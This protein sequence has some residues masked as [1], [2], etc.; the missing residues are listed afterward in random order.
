MISVFGTA[1]HVFAAFQSWSRYAFMDC[2]V[3]CLVPVLV[4]QTNRRLP[5]NY[6]CDK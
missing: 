2:D 1:M 3:L 6:S 5:V 4:H